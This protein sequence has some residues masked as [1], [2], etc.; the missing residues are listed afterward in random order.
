MPLVV[1]ASSVLGFGAF[2]FAVV[3]ERVE[4]GEAVVG[5]ETPAGQAV[6]CA[7]CGARA[8]SKGRRRVVLRDAPAA[9][10]MPVRV[11]WNKRVWAGPNLWCEART[12]T[13]ESVLAGPRRVLTG[14][15]VD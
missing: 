4:A 5:V 14:R 15:A 13:E 10:G 11:W 1:Q 3:A 9:G 7:V 2:G 6:L 12:W 8:R